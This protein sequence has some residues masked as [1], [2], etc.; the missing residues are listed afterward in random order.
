MIAEAAGISKNVLGDDIWFT[1]HCFL[2]GGAQYRF[3]FAPEKRRWSLKLVKWWAGWAPSE[4][5]ET[6][7]RYLLAGVL[8]RDESLLGDSLA[9]DA[10]TH[11]CPRYDD[12]EPLEAPVETQDSCTAIPAS[13]VDGL[14]QDLLDG[15]RDMIKGVVATSQTIEDVT[16][17]GASNADPVSDTSLLMSEL[18]ET[19]SWR[20]Y[21]T[22]YWIANPACHQYRAGVDMLSHERM[23]HRSRLSRMQIIAEFVRGEFQDDL[24]RFEG[25]FSSCVNGDMTVNNIF[26][27]IRACKRQ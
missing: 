12:E 13:F 16:R 5:A 9:P 11:N 21:V 15:L 6:V 27:A 1:F 10:I 3:M 25:E 24:D 23:A 14:K 22:Q 20:D 18:H 4:K 8:D 19:K 2:R 26:A 17:N 7:T